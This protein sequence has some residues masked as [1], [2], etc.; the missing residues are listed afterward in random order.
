MHTSEPNM[1]SLSPHS[2]QRVE[3]EHQGQATGGIP[4][5][6]DAQPP[7]NFPYPEG[8]PAQLMQVGTLKM[9]E[10]HQ[11]P[12]CPFVI[13]CPGLQ[14]LH[15]HQHLAQLAKQQIG[16]ISPEG[17]SQISPNHLEA[18]GQSTANKGE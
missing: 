14:G 13:K 18:S 10:W 12:T 6:A 3:G 9:C 15:Q 17:Q 1:V 4:V 5:A 7:P 2:W 11:P 16:V 8:F